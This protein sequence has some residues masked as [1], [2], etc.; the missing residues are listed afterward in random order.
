MYNLHYICV[1]IYTLNKK[2]FLYSRIEKNNVAEKMECEF[3][4]FSSLIN[5]IRPG[6]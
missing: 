4:T 6:I 5:E 2:R 1:L 3:E